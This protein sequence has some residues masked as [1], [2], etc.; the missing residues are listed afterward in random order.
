MTGSLGKLYRGHK[1]D[2]DEWLVRVVQSMYHNV[3]PCVQVNGGFSDEFEMNVGVHQGSVLTPLLY[4]MV[5]QMLSM[6]F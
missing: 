6:K 4:I 1:L 5:L 2:V 3:Q